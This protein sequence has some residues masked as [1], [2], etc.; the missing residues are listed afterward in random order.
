MVRNMALYLI[1]CLAVWQ[2]NSEFNVLYCFLF[3]SWYDFSFAVQSMSGT[4]DT[5]Q[6][7]PYKQ[8]VLASICGCWYHVF[9][10][11]LRH[12]WRDENR[13]ILF[14]K[15][16]VFAD[17]GKEDLSVWKGKIIVDQSRDR[18][19]WAILAFEF[20]IHNIQFVQSGKIHGDTF[21]RSFLEYTFCQYQCKRMANIE[22]FICPACTPNMVA[23]CADGNRKQYR[24]GT[25]HL[26]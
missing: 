9:G 12:I 14:V 11:F 17:V 24:F 7:W 15:T 18:W 4:V 6:K 1:S 19:V 13:R 20:Y 2:K 25:F 26:G 5:R 23:L 21:Q 22:H 16:W 10:G 3:L 8:W